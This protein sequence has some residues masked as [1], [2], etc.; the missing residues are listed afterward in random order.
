MWKIEHIKMIN[1]Q[2]AKSAYAYKNMK[3]KL[4]KWTKPPPQLYS[5][6]KNIT[7]KM[8]G[9]PVKTCW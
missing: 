1:A 2:Q 3:E 4:L 6:N 5:S 9:I 7:L 8:A